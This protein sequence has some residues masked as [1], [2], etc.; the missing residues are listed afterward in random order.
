MSRQQD[1]K[2]AKLDDY[3]S[4][5]EGD[6]NDSATEPETN[7]SSTGNGK[8]DNSRLSLRKEKK[9]AREK[10]RR[11]RENALFD[12]LATMC[13]VPSDARDK[14]SV[15]KAVI[16]RVEEL[17]ANNSFA[18]LGYPPL[19][20]EDG[21]PSFADDFL[22]AQQRGWAVPPPAFFSGATPGLNKSLGG[23]GMVPG[24]FSGAPFFSM[25][26]GIPS[27]SMDA[28]NNMVPPMTSTSSPTPQSN[29]N[30]NG[31]SGLPS[32]KSLASPG[33]L[34]NSFTAIPQVYGNSRVQ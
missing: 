30:T 28:L 21:T 10:A 26:P 18:R 16:A 29:A 17:R 6:S 9:S 19:K 4:G 33:V 24:Q 11:Q 22:M 31:T 15:L 3:P 1:K 14:S 2:R 34:N 13:N 12:E 32:Q 20:K 7:A 8:T 25:Q 23:I 5:G 27:L